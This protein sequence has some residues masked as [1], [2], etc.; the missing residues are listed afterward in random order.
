MACTSRDSRSQGDRN[1][2]ARNSLSQRVRSTV[3]CARSVIAW[4]ECVGPVALWQPALGLF[5]VRISTRSGSPFGDDLARLGP[6]PTVS[7]VALAFQRRTG[8]STEDHAPLKPGQVREVPS[9][10]VEVRWRR[11]APSPVRS[12]AGSAWPRRR[13][14]GLNR[15]PPRNSSRTTLWYLSLV[16]PTHRARP[17]GNGRRHPRTVDLLIMPDFQGLLGRRRMSGEGGLGGAE[18]IRTPDLRSAIAALSQL[19][20][21]PDRTGRA[22]LRGWP[23]TWPPFTDA[24]PTV[25]RTRLR[26]RPDDRAGSASDRSLAICEPSS[27]KPC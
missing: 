2:P 11:V 15:W 10:A 25:S 27:V 18:G 9:S 17:S 5:P 4:L 21:G 22:R 23:V 8:A 13:F 1:G 12:P 6:P 7:S 16:L 24:L 14:A 3:F 19:S 26:D 20:Y